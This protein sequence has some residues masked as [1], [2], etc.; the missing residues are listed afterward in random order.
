MVS[1]LK[2]FDLQDEDLETILTAIADPI[3]NKRPTVPVGMPEDM[4][5]IMQAC[6]GRYAWPP[7][8]AGGF[9]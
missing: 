4:R 8:T 6:W 5:D 7:C 3:Q 1:C 2:I 9:V